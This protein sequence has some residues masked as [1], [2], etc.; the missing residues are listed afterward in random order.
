MTNR[1]AAESAEMS[2]GMWGVARGE[3]TLDGAR[4]FIWEESVGGTVDLS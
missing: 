4:G 2:L 1:S 3:Y